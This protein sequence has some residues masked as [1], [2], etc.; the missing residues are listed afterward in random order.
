MRKMFA[1]LFMLGAVGLG[2]N[3]DAQAAAFPAAPALGVETLGIIESV[4]HQEHHRPRMHHHHRPRM[5]HHHHRPRVHHHH[6]PRHH[7]HHRPRH[8]HY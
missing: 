5:H 1:A 7:H 8:H 3:G 4:Q 6:R 2:A